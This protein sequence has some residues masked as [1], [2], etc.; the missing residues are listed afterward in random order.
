M[1]ATDS[2]LYSSPALSVEVPSGSIG[3]SLIRLTLAEVYSRLVKQ[4]LHQVLFDPSRLALLARWNRAVVYAGV[5][6]QRV[7]R[8]VILKGVKDS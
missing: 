5:G 3:T 6:E 8:E 7:E 4:V 2:P 1:A